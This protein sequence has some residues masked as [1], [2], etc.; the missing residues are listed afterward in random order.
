MKLYLIKIALLSLIVCPNLYSQWNIKWSSSGIDT[1]VYS[2]YIN[3]QKSGNIWIN[4]LYL[5]DYNK[6]QITQGTYS[7]TPAYSYYFTAAE[8]LA[9]N[10]IYS[11]RTDLNGDN[12]T[13]FYVVSYYGS[14]PNYRKSF[15]IF[16]ITNNNVIFQ[17][18]VPTFSYYN[19]SL[20]DIDGDGFLE[21][22]V[23]KANYPQTNVYYYEVYSTGV[24]G[25]KSEKPIPLNI[26]LKQNFPNPFNPSTIIEYD[27]NQ[28]G[29]VKIDVFNIQGEKVNTLVNE[30]QAAGNHTISWDGVNQNGERLPSGIYFYRLNNV[31]QNEIKKMILLK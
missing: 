19:P 20:Y 30:H 17:R 25:L 1:T 18:D 15:K 23:V 22:I 5:L 14:A 13:D 24:T 21:L 11:L 27:I 4:R 26:E 7:T 9:G 8:Q 2:G 10:Q 3:F 31:E 16:D 29:Q 12:I 28:D 6:F